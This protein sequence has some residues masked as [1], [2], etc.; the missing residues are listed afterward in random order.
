M[1]IVFIN[2]SDSVGGA[3]I[4]ALRI[5]NGL[6]TFFGTDNHLLAAKKKGD[7]PNTQ[8]CRSRLG[9]FIEEGLDRVT[10]RLG[11]QYFWFPV[12]TSSILSNV[13]KLKPDVINLHGI[14]SGYFDTS[15][16][17]KLSLIAPLIWTM[18]DF[19]PITGHCSVPLDCDKWITGCGGCPRKGMYPSIGIDTSRWLFKRKKEIYKSEISFVA[20]SQWLY[21]AALKSPLLDGKNISMIPHGIDTALFSPAGPNLRKKL[22][23]PVYEDV[24]LF[25]AEHTGSQLKGGGY[26]LDILK[27]MDPMLK[28]S[29]HLVIAGKGKIAEDMAFKNITVHNTGLL[30]TEKMP[31]FYR[32]GNILLH[33]TMAESFGLVL[34]EAVSCGV[35]TVTFDVGPTSEIIKDGVSGRVIKP[36]NIGSFAFKTSQLLLDRQLLSS[37]SAWARASAVD[38]FSIEKTAEQYYKLFEDKI[39]QR[40]HRCY[41][42]A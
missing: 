40:K 15:L 29:V 37:F 19:W 2:K 39:N 35:P 24:L 42:R 16:I 30:E 6:R 21:N 36:F 1:K 4:A 22:G 11:L 25:C 9:W 18:H 5:N 27:T 12:S 32:T 7:I 26:L 14:H 34:L 20:P 3:A 41:D 33:P 31:D 10:R 38:R 28:N 17:K 23:I 8:L 13:K